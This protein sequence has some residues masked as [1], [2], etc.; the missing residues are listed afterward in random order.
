MDG[1]IIREGLP[2][3]QPPSAER[4]QALGDRS[5]MPAPGATNVRKR[6]LSD[7]GDNSEMPPPSASRAKRAKTPISPAF[8]TKLETPLS[9]VL[10]DRDDSVADHDDFDDAFSGAVVHVANKTPSVN[11]TPATPGGGASVLLD[12]ENVP[13]PAMDDAD[14]DGESA[15]SELGS[16]L[17]DSEFEEPQSDNILFADIANINRGSRR[18]TIR[19]RHGV[20]SVGGVEKLFSSAHGVFDLQ[21][22]ALSRNSVAAAAIAAHTAAAIASRNEPPPVFG[23]ESSSGAIV[24]FGSD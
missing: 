24:A 10:T 21:P 20:L 5:R 22:M 9:T 23:G 6:P 19:L 18:W 1:V 12:T 4:R 11:V 15:G 8:T 2:D 13:L 16:D 3:E 14:P 7:D 17:D